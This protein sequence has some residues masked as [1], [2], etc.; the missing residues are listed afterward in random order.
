MILGFLQGV[1]EFLPV[2]SSGHLVVYQRLFELSGPG[3]PGGPP[4]T[5]LLFD[6]MVHLGTLIAVLVVFRS[7]IALL[8]S[9]AWRAVT[10]HAGEDRGPLR[11]LL[12]LFVGSIPAAVFGLGW[13]DELE[14]LFA[15]PIYVGLAFLVT[16]S[17]LWLSRYPGRPGRTDRTGHTSRT[18]SPGT[19]SAQAG[20][21]TPPA[22]AG[23][24]TPP[25]QAGSLTPPAQAGS[26]G[27]RSAQATRDLDRTTWI[28]ALLIGL[29]QALA[30]VPGV[31]RSG[32]TISIALML[33][34][35]RR[36]AARYSFLLAVPAILGAVVVQAGDTGGIPADQWTAVAAGTIMAA[37]SG[38]IALRLLLRIVVAGNLSRFSYYCW[39]I[40]LLT[41][42]GVLSGAL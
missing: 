15:A 27:T 29:G 24:P 13:K 12:L 2:S 36:L 1:T 41:L 35:D 14:R 17:L 10:G 4:E 39:G 21:P 20:Q 31:S 8:M 23:Q 38:Y 26:S 6:V 40:G 7:D 22:Q 11:L 16:G 18:E 34:L 32:T 19:R 3:G 9:G 33:G 25:A 42:G 28:D 30:L 37:V 5:R